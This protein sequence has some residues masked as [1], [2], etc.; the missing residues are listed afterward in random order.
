MSRI[1]IVRKEN[2]TIKLIH[3]SGLWEILYSVKLCL[4]V[5]NFSR[6]F[7]MLD[8]VV[9]NHLDQ[10][11]FLEDSIEKDFDEMLAEVDIDSI[12]DDP[13]AAMMMLAEDMQTL[14]EEKYYAIAAEN[15]ITFAKNI[16]DDSDIKIPKSKDG[17]LNE[18]VI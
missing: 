8:K 6:K 12:I 15:G 4:I 5:P 2:I 1:L 9:I 14:L 11:D 13:R 10:M 7:G 18:D 17:N 3:Q 16:R